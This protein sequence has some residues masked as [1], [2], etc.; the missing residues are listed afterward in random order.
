MPTHTHISETSVSAIIPLEQDL[1][2]REQQV[3]LAVKQANSC[4]EIADEFCISVETE[5]S[6][7]KNIIAKLGL[8]GK[9][10]FRRYI[11]KTIS[12]HL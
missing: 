4:K 12:Y 9:V 6:H 8:N 10:A 5:K 11:M 7:R 3:L 1:T 2:F